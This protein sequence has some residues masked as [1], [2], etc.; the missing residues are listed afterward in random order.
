MWVFEMNDPSKKEKSF[1]FQLIRFYCH[2]KNRTQILL[3]NNT[4]INPEFVG[5]TIFYM[6]VKIFFTVFRHIKLSYYFYDVKLY[7]ANN[8]NYIMDNKYLP[9]LC[10]CK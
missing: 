8:L 3:R 4:E 2:T 10:K 6:H 7:Q 9:F 1:L 5:Q